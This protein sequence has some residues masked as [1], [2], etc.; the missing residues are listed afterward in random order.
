MNEP[1][2]PQQQPSCEG[3]HF[4]TSNFGYRAMVRAIHKDA[5]G[6]WFVAESAGDPVPCSFYRDY[7]GPLEQFDPLAE[8]QA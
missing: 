5:N 4:A 1:L 2:K 8:P 6:E 3:W 7:V